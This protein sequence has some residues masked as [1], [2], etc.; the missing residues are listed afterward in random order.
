MQDQ[1]ADA[2][3]VE[4]DFIAHGRG[5][6]NDWNGGIAAVREWN[7][8]ETQPLARFV[9]RGRNSDVSLPTNGSTPARRHAPTG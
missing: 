3:N 5:D 8:A 2:M 4:G 7:R 9:C 6:P 1:L